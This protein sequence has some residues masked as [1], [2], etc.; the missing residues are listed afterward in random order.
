MRPFPQ[1]MHWQHLNNDSILPEAAAASASASV[2]DPMF[3][4]VS[5]MWNKT[6]SQAQSQAQNQSPPPPS[7]SSSYNT[8]ISVGIIE[9]QLL[10]ACIACWLN[11]QWIAV[12][13][14]LVLVIICATAPV[15][16]PKDKNK[17]LTHK[18]PLFTIHENV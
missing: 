11:D 7:R 14:V 8:W 6:Q 1:D 10:A 16:L 15:Y 17:E 3:S 12:V 18:T 5:L 4:D 9:I 2:S 13:C